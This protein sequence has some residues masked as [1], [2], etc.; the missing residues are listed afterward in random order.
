MEYLSSTIV[1]TGES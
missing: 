1:M